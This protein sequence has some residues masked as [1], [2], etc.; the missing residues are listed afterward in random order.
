M[1]FRSIH[2]IYVKNADNV[3]TGNI[4]VT[5]RDEMKDFVDRDICFEN[6]IKRPL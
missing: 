2:G 6:V 3:K 1:L 4:E 5:V